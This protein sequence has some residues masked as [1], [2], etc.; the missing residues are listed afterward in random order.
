MYKTRPRTYT[1]R[2]AFEAAL[3]HHYCGEHKEAKRLL[4]LICNHVVKEPESGQKR[5]QGPSAG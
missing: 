3:W 2:E 4:V 1:I 5:Q